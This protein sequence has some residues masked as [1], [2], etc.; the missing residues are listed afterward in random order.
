M[1]H[2]G[3]FLL[4]MVLSLPVVMAMAVTKGELGQDKWAPAFSAGVISFYALFALIPGVAM[5]WC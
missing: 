5:L 1:K 4:G 3:L 2:I